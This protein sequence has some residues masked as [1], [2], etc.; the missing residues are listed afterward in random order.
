MSWIRAEEQCISLYSEW[1]EAWLD[2]IKRL[3]GRQEEKE[4]KGGGQIAG[5]TTWTLQEVAQRL[6]DLSEHSW[7]KQDTKKRKRKKN[8]L[9]VLQD[10]KDG[11]ARYL[12][13]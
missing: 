1:G 13:D 12:Q 2:L 9:L 10:G 8:S 5:E 3:S 7:G 11:A 6:P 4:K